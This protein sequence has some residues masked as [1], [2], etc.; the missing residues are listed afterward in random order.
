[1]V[2]ASEPHTVES[3]TGGPFRERR[4]LLL[5]AVAVLTVMLGLMTAWN[6][7]RV[8][9]TDKAVRQLATQNRRVTCDVAR[10]RERIPPETALEKAVTAYMRAQVDNSTFKCP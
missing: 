2:P 10:M 1:M 8:D 9:A 6:I 7:T 5:Y 3:L 4:W